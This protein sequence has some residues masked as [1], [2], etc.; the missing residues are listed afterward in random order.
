[1]IR[2]IAGAFAAC[3]SASAALAHVTLE[4]KETP[5]GAG[6]KAVF[7]VPHGCS[8]AATTAI[9][10]R[11]PTGLIAVK[12][13]P[14]PGWTI[15]TV[16]G[17]YDKAYDYY[18][19]AKLTEGVREVSWS[20]GSLPDAYYDEFVLTGFFAPDLEPG[21]MIYFP[22]VQECEKGGVA[23]WIEIPAQGQAEPAMPAPGVKLMPATRKA[24]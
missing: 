10:V 12:P 21:R 16:N 24:H 23:R 1:M 19:G 9:K 8:G 14:K 18:H 2:M 13:M 7:R 20:G 15:E 5:I 11:V 17:K 3:L 22:V 4:S 6:F